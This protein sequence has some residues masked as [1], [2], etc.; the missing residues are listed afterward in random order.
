MAGR[1]IQG[2]VGAGEDETGAGMIKFR[3]QPSG[4]AVALRAGLRESDLDVVGVLG[5]VVVLGVATDAVCRRALVAPA[6]VTGDAVQLGVRAGQGETGEG[7]MIKARARPRVHRGVALLALRRKSQGSVTGRFRAEVRIHVTADAIGG[8]SLVLAD[9]GAFVAGLAIGDRVRAD[10]R[11]AVLVLANGFQRDR[12]A[13]DAVALLALRSHLAAVN[14]GMAI[15]ALVAHV[16]KH[17]IGMALLAGNVLVQA[18][19]RVP[20]LVVIEFR[21]FADRLPAAKRV[22]VLAGNVELAVGAARGFRHT[23][24]LRWN[25]TKRG[26]QQQ[27]ELNCQCRHQ[28]PC[29]F[30][31]ESTSQV[32][33]LGRL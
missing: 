8:Q 31:M 21:H 27:N 14:V 28:A 29:T 2:G 3:A 12:P 22:A 13:V 6:H 20:R 33:S 1:A 17:R 4:R 9:G 18:A 30:P 5:A 7:R 15:G 26:Q 24:W 19:Q 23:R 10:Q 11:E 32:R 16:G 25:A